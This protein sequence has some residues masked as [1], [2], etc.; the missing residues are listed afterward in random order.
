MNFRKINWSKFSGSVCVWGDKVL[1]SG[2][3]SPVFSD[4]ADNQS[5]GG[6]G[7]HT[8]TSAQESVWIVQLQ[9]K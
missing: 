2:G 5:T 3:Q 7:G 4:P 8:W 9:G 1:I 6:R